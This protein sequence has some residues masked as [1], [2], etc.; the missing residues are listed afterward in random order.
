MAVLDNIWDVIWAPANKRPTLKVCRVLLMGLSLGSLLEFVR[1]FE[2]CEPGGR[3][4]FIFEE[5]ADREGIGHD[6]T[7]LGG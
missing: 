5:L 4:F 3:F 7:N 6:G 2:I 1:T